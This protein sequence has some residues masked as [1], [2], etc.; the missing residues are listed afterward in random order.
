M[1]ENNQETVENITYSA[2]D[3]Q[4]VI[5]ALQ[6]IPVSGF[7]NVNNMNAI[8]NILMNNTIEK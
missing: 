5:S 6:Q 3:I 1:G 4:M 8:F 7:Q 2:K